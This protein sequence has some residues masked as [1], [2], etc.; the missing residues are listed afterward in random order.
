MRCCRGSHDDLPER[1]LHSLHYLDGMRGNSN[2][3]IVTVVRR[4]NQFVFRCTFC[5]RNHYHGAGALGHRVAHCTN[6]QSPYRATGYLLV[7]RTG[8]PRATG[9]VYF[10]QAGDGCNVKIGYT[11]DAQRRVQRE[12]QHHSPVPL[13][14]LALV[15]GTKTDEQ[16]L[17][18]M[19][20]HLR[21]HGEWFRP[22]RD[23][24]LLAKHLSSGR[25]SGSL[26]DPEEIEGF[27]IREEAR[28]EP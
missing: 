28:F 2:I 11:K 9:G 19:L 27:V 22:G 5:R 23:L 14:L 1:D 21:L 13:K 16:C 6:P 4:G 15:P 25:F 3:P 17:H 7:E 10:I 18:Q 24:L 20:D 26:C 12:I 8:D